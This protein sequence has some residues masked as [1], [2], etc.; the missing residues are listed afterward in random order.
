MTVTAHGLVNLEGHTEYDVVWPWTRP[1]GL[2]PG[3]TAVLRV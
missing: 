3:A 1:G 2:R